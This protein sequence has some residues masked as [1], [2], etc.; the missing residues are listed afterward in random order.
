MPLPTTVPIPISQRS[1]SWMQYKS[2]ATLRW[3]YTERQVVHTRAQTNLHELLDEEHEEHEEHEELEREREHD[4]H[5][6]NV[7]GKDLMDGHKNAAVCIPASRTGN[8]CLGAVAT[9]TQHRRTFYGQSKADGGVAHT[10]RNRNT[11]R[12]FA[13]ALHYT[14]TGSCRH[15]GVPKSCE[16]RLS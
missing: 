14:T 11:A 3:R 6:K 7:Y 2:A 16:A 13:T 10:P 15:S 5:N 1:D 8:G 9:K 12:S 4:V